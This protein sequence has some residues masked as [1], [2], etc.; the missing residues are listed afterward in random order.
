MV[1]A[2]SWHPRVSGLLSIF[3]VGAIALTTLTKDSH[4]GIVPNTPPPPSPG[5][6]QIYRALR[7]FTRGSYRTRL[8]WDIMS[9]GCG[10]LTQPLS[11]E[12]IPFAPSV[13]TTQGYRLMYCTYLLKMV[14]V[15]ALHNAPVSNEAVN[16]GHTDHCSRM[17]GKTDLIPHDAI[18]TG[19]RLLYV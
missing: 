9:Y 10:T 2:K 13:Y 7:C 18:M 8:P 15:A 16:L 5:G 6:V 12:E 1:T 4:S 19:V 11:L 17:C 14:L 3:V